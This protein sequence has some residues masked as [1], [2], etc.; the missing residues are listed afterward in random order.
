MSTT[1]SL[2][3]HAFD[4]STKY[5]FLGFGC[6]RHWTFLGF[7]CR[8]PRKCRWS[9]EEKYQDGDDL[10]ETEFVDTPDAVSTY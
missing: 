1:S 6:C 7:S 9:K 3:R 2:L 8:D 5:D 10:L 4:D